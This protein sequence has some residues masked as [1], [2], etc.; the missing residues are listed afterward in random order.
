MKLTPEIMRARLRMPEPTRVRHPVYEV[1]G[2][3]EP[4]C[5]SD[6]N[7]FQLNTN[8]RFRFSKQLF[9][10]D[11]AVYWAWTLDGVTPVFPIP[12]GDGI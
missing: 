5:V 8:P 10:E 1:L 6:V 11:G 4:Y 7:S 12:M 3:P 9:R 2:D